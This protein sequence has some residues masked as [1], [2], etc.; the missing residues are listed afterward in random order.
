M[1]YHYINKG[2][3]D[4][5]LHDILVG[6]MSFESHIFHVQ[7]FK[8]LFLIQVFFNFSSYIKICLC[9]IFFLIILIHFLE[10]KMTSHSS[11]LAW[12]IPWIKKV[13]GLPSLGSQKSQ[14]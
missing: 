9:V 14:T 6:F 8:N 12:E 13:C 10:K 4:Y 7:I 5:Y 3:L 2:L 11:I 1:K